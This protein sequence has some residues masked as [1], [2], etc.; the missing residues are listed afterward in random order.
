MTNRKP[1]L[2]HHRHYFKAYYHTYVPCLGE[3]TLKC[4]HIGSLRGLTTDF[5]SL[6]YLDPPTCD[7]LKV[8]TLHTATVTPPQ[9]TLTDSPES[10]RS[11]QDLM[12][13]Y[14]ECFGAIGNFRTQAKLYLKEDA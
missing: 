12:T 9:K 7:R 6:T 10:N 2:G 8:V 5:M 4:K 11:I 13:Q 3:I 14:P 1:S